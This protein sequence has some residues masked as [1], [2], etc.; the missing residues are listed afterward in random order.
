M[1]AKRQAFQYRAPR[2]KVPKLDITTSSRQWNPI[3]GP[4]KPPDHNRMTAT[5]HQAKQP[6][7]SED[8]WGDED[9]EFIMLASQAVEKV[10]AHAEQVI[11]QAMNLHEIDISYGRFRREVEASTQMNKP[12]AVNDIM[13]DFMCSNDDEDLFAKLPDYQ[14]VATISKSPIAIPT[15]NENASERDDVFEM[16]ANQHRITKQNQQK[17]EKAKIEAQTTFLSNKLRDQKREIENLKENLMKI[18]E[19]CQTKEG[20]VCSN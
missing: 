15:V 16:P 18:N 13:N 14:P 7:Q 2:A 3:P 1:M 19:K 17:V 20:E 12:L 6:Q 11:S 9:A 10:D 5:S 4:S 8:M